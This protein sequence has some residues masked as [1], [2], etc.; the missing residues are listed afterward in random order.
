MR[1]KRGEHRHPLWLPIV[2]YA[3]GKT[4]LVHE[5]PIRVALWI[6]SSETEK[7]AAT[8]GLPIQPASKETDTA[9]I[10]EILDS[11]DWASREPLRLT[12]DIPTKQLE[13]GAHILAFPTSASTFILPEPCLIVTREQFEDA[14]QHA[15][16]EDN[17]LSR[18]FTTAREVTEYVTSVISQELEPNLFQGFQRASVT[19]ERPQM[20]VP[21]SRLR[22]H[23]D[24]LLT[25][26]RYA[27]L[28]GIKGCHCSISRHE[29]YLSMSVSGWLH[30]PLSD[31]H[32]ETFIEGKFNSL[33]T[34]RHS[35][36]PGR[37]SVS[38]VYQ[39]QER[40]LEI[41][42]GEMLP[43]GLGTKRRTTRDVPEFA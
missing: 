27:A 33:H 22:R 4:L 41:E 20:R 8:T 13:A 24:L 32:H 39:P 34:L 29:G 43:D 11:P 37:F 23:L 42:L 1:R 9:T 38:H 6:G 18:Q 36:D 17:L 3:L 25:E 14:A 28:G 30:D 5:A 7:T 35:D 19:F 26:F 2:D 12:V 16:E 40:F 31:Q 15:F 10:V 21:V